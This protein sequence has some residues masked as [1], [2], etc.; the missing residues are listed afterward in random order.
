MWCRLP[1]RVDAGGRKTGVIRPFAPFGPPAPRPCVW[2][3]QAR[4]GYF[5]SYL[6]N[7]E[8]LLAKLANIAEFREEVWKSYIKARFDLYEDLVTKYEAAEVRR[9][10]IEEDHRPRRK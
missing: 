5:E 9:K 4:R 1:R 7:H 2:R 8:E 10:Q 3:R 6:G